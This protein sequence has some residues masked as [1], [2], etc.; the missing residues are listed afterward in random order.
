MEKGI[1][2]FLRK[3]LIYDGRRNFNALIF[4]KHE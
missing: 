1:Q 2:L 3:L 4:Y